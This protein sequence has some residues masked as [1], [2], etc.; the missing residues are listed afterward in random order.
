MLLATKV[1]ENWS[2]SVFMC[3]WW[4]G[5]GKGRGNVCGGMWLS[6]WSLHS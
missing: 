4:G 1:R 5:G 2:R 6:S 3:V